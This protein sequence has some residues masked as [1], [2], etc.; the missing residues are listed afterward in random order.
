[1][2]MSQ[3][4]SGSFDD[5][6]KRGE[7]F[8][9]GENWRQF[10][11]ALSEERIA[12]AERSLKLMLRIETLTGLTF[13]DVGSGSGLFSLAA[14]RLGAVVHSFDFDPTS[15]HCTRELR[16]RFFA[17]DPQWIIEEGS[18]L[19]A[20]YLKTLGVFD[21]VYSWGVLHH[22][23]Q[24]WQALKQVQMLV[25]LNG[26]LFIG[27]YNNAGRMSTYWRA[28][29]RTYCR[30]P[31]FLKPLVLYPAFV[32]IWGPRC[33]L[34]VLQLKPFYTWRNYQ[35]K[36]G[37]APWRDVVDWVG[38]YPFEVSTP[39]EVFEFCHRSGF[40]LRKLVSTCSN[41][42]NQFVFQRISVSE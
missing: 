33:L 16:R 1:M 12:E 20:E 38:G 22:T 21:I 34:E 23:G 3:P 10:L 8:E 30:L 37:M 9:F 11:N 17:D 13:V 36:R 28:V 40:E 18:V 14:R 4:S 31:S 5:E 25:K 42:I 19:N 6:V 32:Q 26:K 24:M 27:L 2:S 41:G 29:K 7:R 39:A 35:R 15:V